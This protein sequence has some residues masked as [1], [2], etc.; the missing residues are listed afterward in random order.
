M[1][2]SLES[3]FIPTSHPEP[4]R[5]Q[6][7][8]PHPLLRSGHLQT[9][10]AAWLA[11][12][13]SVG[14]GTVTHRVRL[15]DGDE[16]VL[17]DD[18]P[19]E[20]K[21]VDPVTIMLHGL[22]GSAT[23]HYM[24]RIARKLHARGQRTIRVDMRG[25]GAGHGLSTRPYHAGRSDDLAQIVDWVIDRCPS[26]PLFVV[27]FS[28]GGNITLKWLGEQGCAGASRV[29]RAV[30]V[31]PPVDLQLCTNHLKTI[32]GGLY[33]RHFARLLFQHVQE[34]THWRATI[35]AEWSTRRPRRLI[36]FDELFTAPL[37]G[38]ASAAD[39]Y[40]RA[41]AARVVKQIAV[42]T[43]V[44]SSR[45]DPLI[46]IGTLEGQD[47]PE[48]IRLQF[49]E[50]GGHLGYIGRASGSDPDRNWMDWRVI[51]WLVDGR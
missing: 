22:C 3:P 24:T 28:L 43:M 16:I 8:E 48:C 34:T 40:H 29:M 18:R 21:P 10:A 25:C 39:Y 45:D 27:G 32:W 31:N 6:P 23:S 11:G 17:H 49:A 50:R 51:N 42:P 7:F 30:A 44:L 1:M 9:L 12:K 14:E 13:S 38:F 5:V 20:W 36:E 26:S 2:L 19:A 46:P 4:H 47:W 37:A 15:N 41:S 35:P 33:D